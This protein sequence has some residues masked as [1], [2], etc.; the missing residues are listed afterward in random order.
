MNIFEIPRYTWWESMELIIQN[1]NLDSVT[2]MQNNHLKFTFS[3]S[4]NG[5]FYKNLE[6]SKILKCNIENTF[7]DEVFSYFILDIYAKELSEEE[8]QSALTYYKYGYNVNFSELGKQ[9]LVV[10]IG[11][12]I[13]IDILCGKIDI[14][15][16]DI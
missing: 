15:P 14:I 4:Y 7:E 8:L 2:M 16:H 9:K 11:S 10:I 12:E 3:N 6:C 1:V 5:A 13:C